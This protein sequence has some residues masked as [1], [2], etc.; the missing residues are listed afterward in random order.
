MSSSIDYPTI[1]SNVDTTV[2]PSQPYVYVGSTF[3]HTTAANAP[4]S[5][6]YFS[7]KYLNMKTDTPAPSSGNGIINEF[8]VTWVYQFNTLLND[9]T[10]SDSL[11]I[12]IPNLVGNASSAVGQTYI[13]FLDFKASGSTS[14]HKSSTFQVN[15]VYDNA[16]STSVTCFLDLVLTNYFSS[17]QIST[18]GST[19]IM[20]IRGFALNGAL[21]INQNSPQLPYTSGGLVSYIPLGAGTS[22]VGSSVITSIAIP[23]TYAVGRYLLVKLSIDL[24]DLTGYTLSI[25][26]ATSPTSTSGTTL[27][28]VD[29]VAQSSSVLGI[30][31][32][33]QTG[34]SDP[35]YLNAVCIT[36]ST[37][38]VAQPSWFSVYDIGLMN[39]LGSYPNET[40]LPDSS[41]GLL[42]DG[43]NDSVVGGT[44]ITAPFPA[45]IVS[46]MVPSSYPTGR[47]LQIEGT[48][49]VLS[50]LVPTDY[51]SVVAT[52]GGSTT[53]LYEGSPQY[54]GFAILA[55][56]PTSTYAG[57]AVS[58]QILYNSTATSGS[59][60]VAHGNPFVIYDNGV[61]P[62]FSA[63]SPPSIQ[64]AAWGVYGQVSCPSGTSLVPNAVISSQ[65]SFLS[66]NIP[67][68]YPQGR[69]LRVLGILTVQPPDP[70]VNAALEIQLSSGSS[71]PGTPIG[72]MDIP[73]TSRI[74]TVQV[75]ALYQVPSGGT[76]GN[77]YLNLWWAV[78]GNVDF[79]TFGSAV[80]T[81][82]DVSLQN[83]VAA[84]SNPWGS[85]DGSAIYY[86]QGNVG[87][88]TQTP[89]YGLTVNNQCVSMGSFMLQNVNGFNIPTMLQQFA[90][91][92][93]VGS[94]AG[95]S[96]SVDVSFYPP[97]LSPPQVYLQVHDTGYGESCG[98]Q[99]Y[100]ISNEGCTVYGCWLYKAP[101]DDTINF[102]VLA[103]GPS[104]VIS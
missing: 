53:V 4:G 59:V 1:R 6:G 37:T 90:G 49:E 79:T 94:S 36:N 72:Y 27:A 93:V 67:T 38:T 58:I 92:V 70:S 54:V 88:G 51:V 23:T 16:S 78:D 52:S 87:I 89:S 75:E 64:N 68:S 20:T 82:Q 71:I 91:T 46:F 2:P 95:E 48:L 35:V 74:I 32:V 39:A 44:Q 3:V 102:F 63:A 66:I 31:Q 85:V 12:T 65:G 99:A 8:E 86:D 61:D 62:F 33:P 14:S 104:T 10:P 47:I 5:G 9:Q 42:Y 96:G 103:I 73:A 80:L 98:L 81:V 97:F 22:V 84:P 83:I 30:Y 50:T 34:L 21:P 69:W 77:V 28:Y 7:T 57:E 15:T 56:Y 100:D 29:S 13:V 19:N 11:Y 40:A 101:V 43:F 26:L 17:S 24:S 41:W 60:V 55:T 45:V 25:V 18:P 76:Q